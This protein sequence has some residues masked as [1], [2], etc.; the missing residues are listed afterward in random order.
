MELYKEIIKN[1]LENESVQIVFPDLQCNICD[2]IEKRCYQTLEDEECF[3]K[4]EKILCLFEELGSG[5]SRHDF[6]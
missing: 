1:I 5:S 2:L 4:I 3:I 6:A